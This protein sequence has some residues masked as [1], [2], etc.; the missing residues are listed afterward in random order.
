MDSSFW[1]N[2][3]RSFDITH[4]ACTP[5]NCGCEFKMVNVGELAYEIEQILK[6]EKND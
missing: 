2:I 6:G 5:G 4:Y 3:I 1:E